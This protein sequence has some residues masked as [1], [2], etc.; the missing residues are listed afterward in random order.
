MNET[1]QKIIELLTKSEAAIPIEQ[2]PDLP[3]GKN[4]SGAP[5]WYRF[6]HAIWAFGGDIRRL[7]LKSKFLRKDVELQRAIL[8]VAIDPKAKRG[9]QSFIM[10]LGYL[11]CVQFAPQIAEQLSDPQV[12]GHAIDTLSKMKCSDYVKAIEPFTQDNLYSK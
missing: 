11:A 3:Q 4:T 12:C 10:L 9:R 5:E 8:R 7:F 2:K 1:R 6:E